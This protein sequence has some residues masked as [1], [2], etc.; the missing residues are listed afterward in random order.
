MPPWHADPAVGHFSN[1]RHMPQQDIDLL[2]E[3]V[4]GGMPKGDEKELPA[5]IQYASGW[6]LPREPDVVLEMSR[7]PFEV[8]ASGTVE[9][10]YFVVDPGFTED[11]WISAA[12]VIPGNRS[13][14]HHAIVFIRPPDGSRF[15]GVGWLSGYVPGQ[16]LT[17]APAGFA[18]KVPAG[19]KLVF[20]MHYTP[21]GSPQSDLS[22]IGLVK[23]DPESVTHE[24]LNVIG[25][26]QEFEIP[27]GAAAFPVS[28]KVGWFPRDGLL[29]GCMPHMHLRGRSF[30]MALKLKDSREVPMLNV[31]QYDFNWQHF[32]ML[33]QP[34][35]L[36]HVDSMTF[37]A[38][39]DNSDDNPFNP[40]PEEWVGW[41]DQT[42]E[43]M[44]V[45]FLEVAE[46]LASRDRSDDQQSTDPQKLAA[47]QQERDRKVEKFVA[48][49]FRRLDRDGDGFVKHS[50]TPMV[51]RQFHFTRYDSNHDLSITRDEVRRIAESRFR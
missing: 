21:T 29:M 22:R 1:A 43:E 3:W 28:G 10:Q 34:L 6:R 23:A 2:R 46:P 17:T 37:T 18:R 33:E 51:I 31:P 32:Y 40:N 15:R 26:D 35:D 4:R 16:R 19:S 9:Y 36:S 24:V 50:E 42:W 48:D 20:Q 38:T 11:T 7:Q 44:A 13:V 49:F 25:I 41:G 14:V 45:V 47:E 5:P 8:P 39:F 30:E 27:P 12:Q